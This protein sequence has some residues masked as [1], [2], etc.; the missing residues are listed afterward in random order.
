MPIHDGITGQAPS[1]A[2]TER[3]RLRKPCL[4]QREQCS[5][6]CGHWGVSQTSSPPG[7]LLPPSS[8]MEVRQVGFFCFA[9]QLRFPSCREQQVCTGTAAAGY[10]ACTRTVLAAERSSF[11][12]STRPKIHISVCQAC[13][14]PLSWELGAGEAPEQPCRAGRGDM[15]RFRGHGQGHGQVQGSTFVSVPC[16]LAPQEHPYPVPCWHLSSL[17]DLPS[18]LSNVGSTRCSEGTPQTQ[19]AL[20]L[21]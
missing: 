7:F 11:P 10:P 14:T 16:P 13:P 5:P 2:G 17:A 21:G 19:S 1:R 12:P 3:G 18:P 9:V 8:A 20:L 6:S 4:P 15:G